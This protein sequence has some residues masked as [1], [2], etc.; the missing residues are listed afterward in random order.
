M[1]HLYIENGTDPA[2][3][4]EKGAA[5]RIGQRIREVRTVRGL[6]MSE[7]GQRVGLS[8]DRIQKY[9]NGA[10][11]PKMAMLIKIAEALEC[12]TLALIDPEVSSY[13]GAMQAFFE[14]EKEYNVIIKKDE[15]SNY[16]LSFKDCNHNTL[17]EY[18][19][20][21]EKRRRIYEAERESAKSDEE[22]LSIKDKYLEWQFTFP[23][24]LTDK[25]A[26]RL[27]K[28]RV[29]EAIGELQQILTELD[30]D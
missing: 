6:S 12:S 3:I 29:E 16:S 30:E 26:K 13:L 10:R 5:Q 28:Q 7:L 18:L 11:K 20:E 24:A 8:A 25:T 4:T 9:E 23:K 22:R 1:L 17:K 27:Q 15:N 19:R 14:L 2:E 21:W